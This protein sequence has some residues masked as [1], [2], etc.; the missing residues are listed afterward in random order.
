MNS[1]LKRSPIAFAVT[2]ALAFGAVAAMPVAAQDSELTEVTMVL[3][4][5]IQGESAGHFVAVDQG[6]YEDA[7]LDVTI[8]PGGPDVNSR[9]L[10]TSGAAD[11]AVSSTPGIILARNQGVP[12]VGLWTQNQE[13]G[14]G[15]V[16]KT[17]TGI[18]SWDDLEGKKVGIWVGLGEPELYYAVESVG[19]SKEDVSWLPQKFSMIE[20]FEDKFDCASVT[21]W[22]E[23]HVVTDEGLTMGEDFNFLKASDLGIFLSG[24][25]GFT[26]EQMIAE[27]PE[28]V[29]AFTDASLRGW[30]HALDFPEDAV[31]ATMNWAPDLDEQKQVY[32]VE[33]VNRLMTSGAAAD[34][35]QIGTMT[36]E[37]FEA[38][39]EALLQAG[40]LEAPIDLTAAF[41]TSFLENV[42][43]EYTEIGDREALL[44]RIMENLGES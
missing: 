34:S 9:L 7:G 35:G 44:E 6:Y 36:L 17:E 3:P 5:V 26:T 21:V 4:W 11:F 10:L 1:S 20:F 18:D 29:Q 38:N 15:L 42:P 19:V 2:A 27:N 30:K 8:I 37:A 23:L 28:I 39:Q 25:S 32:Q 16:C 24:D 33:E 40:V 43:A 14:S 12:L 22:N 31:A 13:S 41:D